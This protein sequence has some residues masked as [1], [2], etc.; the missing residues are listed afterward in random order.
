MNLY[1]LI[2]SPDEAITLEQMHLD[3]T[4]RQSIEQI[5][6]EQ[7]HA[8]VLAQYGL[9]L[10]NKILLTGAS[11]LGKT[12]AAK[13]MAHALSRPLL[14]LNLSNL[15]SARIGETAQNL[16]Q[17]FDKA[18]R[19]KAILFLDEFDHIGKAR[20]LEDKEV[21]EMRR[22]VNSLIQLMDNY[23]QTALLMAATN[24]PEVVDSALLRRFQVRIAFQ[25][26]SKAHLDAYYDQLLSKFPS[27]FTA[28]ERQYQI[29]YAVAKDLTYTQVKKN[30]ISKLDLDI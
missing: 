26:P 16:K 3:P 29:S 30:L 10:N 22:L 27:E 20:A 13:A 23:P 5:V 2:L 8:K 1:D 11:G 9:P 12:M 28:I 19:D 21:G 7:K 6:K 17:I 24:H 4:Q 15:V 25:M 18:S 14:I